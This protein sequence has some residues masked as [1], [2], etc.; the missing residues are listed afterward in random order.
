MTGT[1]VPGPARAGPPRTGMRS[2]A[3]LLAGRASFR[4]L[5]Y[6]SGPL[7][8]AAW[9]RDDFNRYAAAVGSVTWLTALVQAGPEKAALKLVPRSHRTLGDTLGPLRAAVAFLPIPP[10]VVAVAAMLAAPSATATLYLTAAAYQIALGC[11]L[12]G[13]GVHRAL[14]RTAPDLAAYAA[15]SAGTAAMTGLALTA[16]PPPV[17]YIGALLAVCAVLNVALARRLPRPRPSGRRRAVRRLLAGTVLLMGAPEAMTNAATSLLYVELTLSAHAGQSGRLYLVLM[18]WSLVI[19]TGYFVQRMF[20][21]AASARLRGEGAAAGQDRARR[22]ARLVLA[23]SAVWLA[24]A[25]A[26]L[27]VAGTRGADSLVLLGVLLVSRAPLYLLM[28]YAAYLLENTGGRDLRTSAAGGAA[29]LVAV[30]ATG[31]VTVPL[32]G[33][34]GAVY[35]LAA[36]ELVL[37]AVVLARLRARR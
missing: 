37:G 27:A 25:G 9:G 16:G 6:L 33:A 7:L 20:Q 32:C 12:L 1:R 15:L 34:A 8:L 24:V 36:K 17:V 19:A 5:L 3:P 11:T 22:I 4:V 26:V 35:A 14:G 10:A 18:A 13:A 21:P 23:G 28:S 2:L 31:A 30:V 29:G